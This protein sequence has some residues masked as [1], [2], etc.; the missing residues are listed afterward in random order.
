LSRLGRRS[1]LLLLILAA[2]CAQPQVLRDGV[3]MPYEQAATADLKEARR[4][5]EADDLDRAQQVLER[6]QV[7]LADSRRADEALF[8]LAELYERRD[9]PERAALAYRRLGDQYPRSRY[10]AEARLRAARIYRDLGRPEIGRRILAEARFERAPA[11][12][13][14]DMHRLAADLARTQGDYAAAVYELAY[15]RRDT[16][17]REALTDIDL[18][19]SE[20]ID[21]RLRDS[22]LAELSERLP[23]GP[24]YDRVLLS[25]ARR[26]LRAGDYAAALETLERLPQR[27]RLVDERTRQQLLERARVGAETELYELGLL[28]PLSG[29]YASFGEAVL[30][31]VV[32]GLGVFEESPAPFHVTVRDTEGDPGKATAALRELSDAGVRAIIGPMRSVV[33]EPVAVQAERQGIPLLSLAPRA[34]L[35]ELGPHVFRLGLAPAEQVR[36]LVQFGFERCEAR[37]FAVLYPRDDYGT[38]FKNLFWDEVERL[39]GEIVGVEGYAPDAVDMQKEIR[40]LVGLEYLTPEE[41]ELVK[42]RDRLLKRRVDNEE[43]L[44]DPDLADLPPYVDFDALFIPDAATNIGL[45][46]PQLRFY[47]VRG[48]TT[49]GSRDWND[50]E[51]VKIAGREA[52][53]AVF[54]DGFHAES[55]DPVT[56]DFVSRFHAS[57]GREPD[58]S[59]AIG[60]DAAL[61]LRQIIAESSYPTSSRLRDALF[62]VEAYQGVSGLTAFDDAGGPIMALR[63]LTVRRGR[64]V[65]VDQCPRVKISRR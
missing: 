39:G 36:S 28:L 10:N 9:D 17:E 37:R 24:V 32:L 8:L 44:A 42:E 51:L 47:D 52:R 7:E 38:S 29:P 41:R 34:N 20:L 14:A 30:R 31:G 45:I 3:S 53:G 11:A 62:G 49:M 64:I 57:F 16:E 61:I 65:E 48:V 19:L 33:A 35:A 55:T 40:K 18:E 50:P 43:R 21:D 13:R 2:A 60:Y 27:L 22:E 1:W 5:I 26:Q 54:V 23:R 25:L 6:F 63:H 12:L 15:A 56:R 58:A 4:A 46:L 59:A